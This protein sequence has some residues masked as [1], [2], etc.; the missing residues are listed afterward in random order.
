M[1]SLKL[2]HKSQNLTRR[3]SINKPIEEVEEV[4]K[5]VF[6]GSFTPDDTG[7]FNLTLERRTVERGKGKETSVKKNDLC[8]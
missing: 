2:G 8:T 6:R 7:R 1:R 4:Q 3:K 5:R